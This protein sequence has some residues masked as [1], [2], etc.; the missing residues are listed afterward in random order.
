MEVRAV[1]KYVKVQPRKVRLL[2]AEVRGKPAVMSA[3][4]LKYHPSKG[5]F[6]LRK[7]LVSAMANAVENHGVSVENLRISNIQV[8]EG[9]RMKRISQRAQGRGN[10]IIKKTSHIMVV[11]EDYEPQV[12]VKPHGTKAK[13]RPKFDAPKPARKKKSEEAVAET[14]ATEEST[15]LAEIA[16]VQEA[17]A[18]PALQSEPVIPP[19]DAVEEVAAAEA[20]PATEVQKEE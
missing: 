12:K 3:Q 7:V 11:V 15:A 14:E 1:A 16:E 9:P 20:D 8:D 10:R 18:T 19:P 17:E 2:A 4:L 6:T 5:A 13:A